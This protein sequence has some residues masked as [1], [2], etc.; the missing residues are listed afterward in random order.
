MRQFYLVV[1]FN[2]FFFS[3]SF[4]SFVGPNII[5]GA[6]YAGPHAVCEIQHV[7][8]FV[9]PQKKQKVKEMLSKFYKSEIIYKFF[10][11]L[12]LMLIFMLIL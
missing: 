8:I 4:F 1:Y 2:N 7:M 3:L 11:I 12:Q 9:L 5:Y 6:N 10:I